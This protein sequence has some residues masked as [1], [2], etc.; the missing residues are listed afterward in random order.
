MAL[1]WGVAEEVL[2]LADMN[3]GVEPGG[4]GGTGGGGGGGYGSGSSSDY[5][6]EEEEDGSEDEVGCVWVV[7]GW[8]FYCAKLQ[9]VYMRPTCNFGWSWWVIRPG[10]LEFVGVRGI[11]VCVRTDAS[12]CRG[13]CFLFICRSPVSRRG[14]SSRYNR[15]N[16]RPFTF[17]GIGRDY[18]ARLLVALDGNVV[19]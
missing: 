4:V 15:D 6:D 16:L 14:C 11:G 18:I 8:V 10:V 12:S 13:H 9:Q 5:D 17:A 3:S 2:R 7:R 19:Q 1:V